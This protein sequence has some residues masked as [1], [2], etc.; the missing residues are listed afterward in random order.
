MSAG[1]FEPTTGEI[2]FYTSKTGN[3]N[4]GSWVEF[5]AYF[6]LGKLRELHTIADIAPSA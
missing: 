2:Q 6:V 4:D 5:S 1:Y 3:Y